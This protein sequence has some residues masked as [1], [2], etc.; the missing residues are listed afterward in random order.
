M[1]A[2]SLPV[3]SASF[4]VCLD[5]FPRR[6]AYN[7]KQLS[8]E[9]D[10]DGFLSLQTV[11]AAATEKEALEEALLVATVENCF[12]A[13][14]VSDYYFPIYSY[15]FFT[16]DVGHFNF[17]FFNCDFF[18]CGVYAGVKRPWEENRFFLPWLF[19]S[20]PLLLLPLGRATAPYLL[21]FFPRATFLS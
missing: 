2:E 14:S 5:T 16:D 9:R 3:F 13:N 21:A 7:K 4:F 11:Q 15:A 17:M 1:L 12:A 6:R 18:V 20:N 19:T 8:R 10:G